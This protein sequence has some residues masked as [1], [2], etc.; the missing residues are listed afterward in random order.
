MIAPLTEAAPEHLTPHDLVTYFRCPHEM[1]LTRTLH[2]KA[3]GRVP[4]LVRTP[5]DVVP[6]R[7]S[8]MAPPPAGPVR[9]SEGRLDITE[10]DLLVYEDSGEADLPVLFPPERVRLD[11][12]FTNG[13]A[14]LI[15]AELG[16]AGRPDLVIQR[17][18]VGF[19]PLEF[20]STHLFV[21]YH[22][23]HGR[24][25]DAVQA[26]AECRLVQAVFGRRP[27]YG[28]VLY[29]DTAGGGSREGW[30]EVSYG[31]AEERWLRAVV[32]QVRRDRTRAPVPSERTCGS[33]EP[34]AEGLCRFAATRYEGP[35]HRERFLTTR[36]L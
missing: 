8:P 17:G 29:G 35:H 5:L 9:V 22:E 23:A 21:G 18:D 28:V 27:E 24:L 15:D 16:I 11:P 6:L 30:V 31:E 32:D 33:C 36:V 20:K 1:E 26:I 19:V 25:F 13:H 3:M 7:H 14:N 4:P 34:N 10:R 12:R 2:A